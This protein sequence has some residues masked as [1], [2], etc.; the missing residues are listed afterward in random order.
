MRRIQKEPVSD[1][2]LDSAKKFMIGSFPLKF[3]RQSSIA[4]FM[5]Q[6][7]LYH[8]GLD[9]ADRYP[10]IIS[11][12]TKD[13]V[14]R[15][16]ANICIRTPSSWSPPR[17]KARLLLKSEATPALNDSARM[18]PDFRRYAAARAASTSRRNCPV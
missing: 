15:S 2:E 12:I 8:L 6:V 10:Q 4:S 7:E 1:A 17:I 13:D 14:R 11:E 3:D 9:Y 5:L 18:P 16:R